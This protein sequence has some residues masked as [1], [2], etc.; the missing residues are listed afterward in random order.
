V[1]HKATIEDNSLSEKHLHHFGNR[2]A[3]SK[4][5]KAI[6]WRECINTFKNLGSYTLS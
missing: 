2:I 3:L 5:K 6:L 4:S 1:S